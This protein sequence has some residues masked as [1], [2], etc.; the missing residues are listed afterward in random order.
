MIISR[1]K[2]YLF[3]FVLAAIF[4]ISCNDDEPAAM[5]PAVILPQLLIENASFIEGSDITSGVSIAVQLEGTST[6][7]VEVGYSIESGSAT[8]DE[9]FSGEIDGV[10]V[11]D[12]DEVE[13]EI[14]FTILGDDVAEG[15][16]DFTI[17][18]SDPVNVTLRSESIT[19]TVKDDDARAVSSS[20]PN[21]GFN[22][23]I[24]YPEM[25]LLWSNE[26]VA[27]ELNAAEWTWDL[28]NGNDGWGN[29]ESQYYREENTTVEGG[30][31]VIT[32]KEENFEG[33]PYTSSRIISKD[34]VEFQFGRI[35]IRAA[36]PQGQGLWPAL[37]M[38][39]AN[40]DDIGWPACGEIDIMELVGHE[41][42]IVHGTAHFG[43]NN[44]ERRFL[45]RSKDLGAGDTFAEE[46]HVFSLIWERNKIRWL[47]DDQQYHIL[48]PQ[49]VSPALW[50]FN[51]NFF[52]IFNVAV[53]GQWPGYPD[54]TTT[55]PQQMHVDYVRVFQEK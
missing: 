28:G 2:T 31:L 5:E 20:A 34:K 48:T 55:F 19:I 12:G 4:A 1:L 32:A 24:S 22:S 35:D 8:V 18:L 39:G 46:F 26:F 29:R 42:G 44:S 27:D 11:F 54:A 38:L 43:A 13:Q 17:R 52:M 21:G 10:L 51:K 37:W 40:I 23:P 50:P 6:E 41:P 53:G 7:L 3:A 47:L 30:N 9:D 14:K 15:D 33:L 45:G 36:M 16:E 49:D 25:D